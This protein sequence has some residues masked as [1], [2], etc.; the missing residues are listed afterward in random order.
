MGDIGSLLARVG[1]GVFQQ[2]WVVDDLP[3]AEA[4]M[5]T[6]LGCSEFTKFRMDEPWTLRGE[7]VSCAFDL[8]FARSGNLQIEL[9][10]PLGEVGVQAEFLATHGPSPHHWGVLVGD[11]DASLGA[12]AND[13]FPAVMHGQFASVRL[14]FVD[15][16]EDLGIYLELIEDPDGMLW[17]TRPWRDEA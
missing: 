11:L 16:V 4:A 6:S 9:M 1:G 5:Q 2:A 15:T 3:A 17:A 13:G 14:A 7:P 10:Q 12:A 8:G